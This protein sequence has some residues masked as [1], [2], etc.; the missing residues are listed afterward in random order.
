[1]MPCGWRCKHLVCSKKCSELCDRKRCDESCDRVLPCGHIC[2]GVCG[3]PCVKCVQC[4]LPNQK[5]CFSMELLRDLPGKLYQL[6]CGHIFDLKMLDGYMETEQANGGHTAI[7]AKCCPVCRSQVHQAPRYNALVKAQL[8]LIDAVKKEQE[9]Q[10][11]RELSQAER[12][13]ID[14]AI[15]QTEGRS[16][17]AGNWFACPNGHPYYIGECGG[18][19][20]E[21]TC[22]ECG[23]R[24]GGGSHSL[25]RDNAFVADFAGDGAAAPAWPGMAGP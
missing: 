25:R 7:R 6:D 23:A 20:Q 4:F 17:G 13:D 10:H 9:Q 24:V 22:P 16:T 3:E 8:R 11:R 15:G 2:R 14:R 19:M 18:A 21:S 5:C 1:M 12:R